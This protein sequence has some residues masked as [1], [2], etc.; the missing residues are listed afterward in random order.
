MS[1][2]LDNLNPIVVNNLMVASETPSVG[3]SALV[4]DDYAIPLRN[5][6]DSSDSSTIVIREKEAVFTFPIPYDEEEQNLTLYVDIS[7]DGN[8]DFMWDRSDSNIYQDTSGFYRR[9]TMYN[10]EDRAKMK[11]FSNGHFVPVPNDG[12][13]IP[14]YG[15]TVVFTLDSEML[16]GYTPG[17][18]YYGRYRW[19]DIERGTGDWTGF[20]FTY[21]FH[22]IR[23]PKI[24]KEEFSVL[25]CYATSNPNTTNKTIE[26]QV[27]NPINGSYSEL[28]GD[29]IEVLYDWHIPE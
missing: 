9:I 21:D 24:P 17:K 20:I 4:V 6:V 5:A 26:V 3:D 11:I 13:N 15:E 10:P 28:I 23:P 12:V 16:P 14:Y 22:D 1:S 2:S 18:T 29:P 8:F 7:E 27:I 19:Y 25:P